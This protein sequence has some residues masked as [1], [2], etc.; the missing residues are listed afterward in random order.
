[1]IVF[2]D[3]KY[4]K[5]K[6]ACVSVNDRAFVFA[7]GVYEGLRVYNNKLFKYEEHKIRFQRSLDELRIKYVLKNEIQEIYE[8]LKKVNGY[9]NDDLFYY[10]HISRG[11]SPRAHAFPKENTP[12]GIYAF[13]VP[14]KLNMKKYNEGVSVCT[15]SDNRWARCDIKCISL[16]ANCLANQIAVDNGCSDALF[17]HD[18]VITEGTHTNV[19]FIKNNELYT[20]AKTNRILA[21]VTRN[22]VVEL[23]KKNGINVHEF[24]LIY[25][26]L[27]E[28]DESFLTGT[29]EELTPITHINGNKVGS[30]KVGPL[31]KKLQKLFKDEVSKCCN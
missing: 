17:I 18:G 27:M 1:M 25:D 28:I 31:T 16:V 9:E 10:I 15:V 29:T 24:P 12:I 8:A 5:E 3:G 19:F 6:E 11:K 30:G 14:K 13:L 4:V 7:D 23:C 2:V 20:H 21:G 26:K 22:T